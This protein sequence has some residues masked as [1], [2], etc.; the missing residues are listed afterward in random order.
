MN[1]H[2][3]YGLDIVT[4]HAL[5]VPPALVNGDYIFRLVEHNLTYSYIDTVKL[6][7]ILNNGF[8]VEFPLVYANRSVYG[9][10]L[11]RLLYS[12]NWHVIALGSNFRNGEGSHYIDFRFA[13]PGENLNIVSFVF[14]I[15]G[16]N[17]I[18]K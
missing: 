17:Y 15:E 6:F 7:D 12:D 3:I 13:S 18:A 16:H 2:N 11:E 10:V 5:N 8:V 9:D 14:Q 1:I 4:N